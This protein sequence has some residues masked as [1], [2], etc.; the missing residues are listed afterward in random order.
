MV[1][2]SADAPRPNANEAD[3]LSCVL[4]MSRVIGKANA[5]ARATVTPLVFLVRSF[6]TSMREQSWDVGRGNNSEDQ[7]RAF[8]RRQVDQQICR[9][10]GVSRSTVR[11]IIRSGATEFTYDRTTQPRPKIDPR[12]SE[13]GLQ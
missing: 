8:C 2:S 4:A 11:K 9:E 12:R 6:L 10:L 7:A 13:Q 1:E 5:L 3:V